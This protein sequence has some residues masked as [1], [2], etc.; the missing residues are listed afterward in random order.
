[1]SF[2][3]DLCFF[4]IH[5]VGKTESPTTTICKTEVADAIDAPIET[6][7]TL[8]L[9]RFPRLCACRLSEPLGTYSRS[10]NCHFKYRTKTSKI[11]NFLLQHS[12]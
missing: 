4:K 9:F 6:H 11:M 7:Q 3:F 2:L 10:S 5:G 12:V 8:P 1:M